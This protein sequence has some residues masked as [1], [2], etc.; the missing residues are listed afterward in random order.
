MSKRGAPSSQPSG[1]KDFRIGFLVHDVSRVRSTL[2]DSQ[3]KPLGM[4][5]SRWW[6][7]A[8]LSR[9]LSYNGVDGML[10]TELAEIMDVGKVTVG[11]LMDHLEA[12]GLVE[13]RP[14]PHDRRAKRV[15][16]TENG[17][18]ALAKMKKVGQRLNRQV[19]DGIPPEHVKIAEDVLSRMRANIVDI[20]NEE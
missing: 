9:S 10:Q 13:R 12:A 18:K 16:I 2:F 5:R 15:H 20:L 11:G 8:Q 17:H 4:T 14:D 1:P 6:A 3:M 19:L 7:L